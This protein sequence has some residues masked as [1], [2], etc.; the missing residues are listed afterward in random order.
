MNIVRWEKKRDVVWLK[1]FHYQQWDLPQCFRRIQTWLFL[2]R[3]F[4]FFCLGFF[5]FSI[6]LFFLFLATNWEDIFCICRTD[7]Q[8]SSQQV[9]IV[10]AALW[11]Y[12]FLPLAIIRYSR[13]CF[14]WECSTYKAKQTYLATE[15]VLKW[16]KEIIIWRVGIYHSF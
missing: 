1:N 15:L 16:C 2:E 10:E 3:E 9:T 14:N 5:F 13:K 11:M 6:F 12:W 8:M 4:E 7:H